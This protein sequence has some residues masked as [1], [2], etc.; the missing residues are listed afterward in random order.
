[1]QMTNEA[2]AP[3][4]TASA[5]KKLSI[6]DPVAAEDLAKFSEL[7]NA[8][9]QVAERVL[10]LEQEKIRTLRAASNIDTERQ[11]LFEKVLLDRGLPP[12]APVEIDAKTG[13]ISLVAPPQPAQS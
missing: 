10:D 13:K 11:R 7:Q 9:M 5:E 2:A 8:R 6:D 3:T 1:M 4:P 12:T